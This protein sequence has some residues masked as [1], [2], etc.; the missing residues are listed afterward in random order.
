MKNGKRGSVMAKSSR[1][2]NWVQRTK[3]KMKM[4]APVGIK[5][6]PSETVALADIYKEDVRI[7]ENNDKE[8]SKAIKATSNSL[9]IGRSIDEAKS[10]RSKAAGVYKITK[11]PIKKREWAR[12]IVVADQALKS[13]RDVKTR[14]DVTKDRLMMIKGDLELQLMEAESKAQEM[15]AYAQAGKGLRLVGETLINA[16]SR[17]SNLSLEYSNLEVTMEGAEGLIS[18]L[19]PEEIVAQADKIV[20]KK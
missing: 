4:L 13:M 17:A 11:D 3:V 9:S 8:L 2:S 7:I 20:G 5:L 12:R 10:A 15:E 6:S 1:Q 18:S 16:R 19:S 14:M